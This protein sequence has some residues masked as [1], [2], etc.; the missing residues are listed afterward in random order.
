MNPIK[1]SDRIMRAIAFYVSVLLFIILLPILLSYALGYK[2]DYGKFR[3]YKTGIIYIESHPAGASVYIDG[4][5]I[6]D[7]T[8]A[9]IEELKPGPYKVAVKREGFYPWERELV[10]RPNMVTK[11]DR[12]VLFP[13]K[14]EM[15]KMGERGVLDFAISEGGYIYYFKKSGLYRSAMDGIT[16][17][18]LSSYS[19]WPENIKGKR[20]SPRGDEF[21]YFT[22]KTVWLARPDM[23][24]VAGKAGEE[25]SIEEVYSGQDGIKDVFWYPGAGYIL[26]VT[27]KD[28]KVAELGEA[29]THNVVPLYKFNSDPR[30]LRFDE[31]TG[32]IYFTDTG[33]GQ[34][35]SESRYLYRIDLK[36][37]FFDQ[38]VK[39]L[40]KTEPDTGYEKP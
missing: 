14:Q 27:D 18:R 9:R 36:E 38:L 31:G 30:G 8:P 33:T 15:K 17:K 2:I 22:D 32:S 7:V 19:A 24:P 11:A 10:A 35:F 16:M 25:M 20:F 1:V 12:I 37:K 13:V 29:G 34:D 28:I 26:V 6:P 40:I 39:R 23:S 21:L 5:Q 4:R 3:I